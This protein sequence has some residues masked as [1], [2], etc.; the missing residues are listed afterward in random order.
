MKMTERLT[1]QRL[2]S[3]RRDAEDEGDQARLERDY[4]LGLRVR[5]LRSNQGWTLEELARRAGVS[6]D[7]VE[8]VELGALEGNLTEVQ[9]I[10]VA[11]NADLEIR[12]RAS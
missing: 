4:A 8:R 3:M 11:L 1:L 5:E 12:I 10:C 7:A 6:V 2:K 9:Q